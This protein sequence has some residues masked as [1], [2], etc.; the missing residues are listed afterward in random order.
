MSRI[1]R[2]WLPLALAA[3]LALA[4]GGC[5]TTA[6]RELQ[7]ANEALEAARE[8]GADEHATEDYN[9]AEEAFAQAQQLARDQRV[10]EARSMAVKAKILAEDARNKAVERQRILEA[11]MERLTK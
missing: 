9:A 3:A 2:I 1:T 6:D 10:A 11:E 4:A 8:V 7:R 5:D